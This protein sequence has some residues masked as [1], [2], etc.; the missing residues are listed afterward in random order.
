MAADDAKE[1][2]STEEAKEISEQLD[3][4]MQAEPVT[5]SEEDPI[6]SEIEREA[7]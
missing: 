5:S 4:L 1:D 7:Y 3:E 2:G 6:D